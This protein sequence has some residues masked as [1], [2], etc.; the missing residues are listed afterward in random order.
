MLGRYLCPA[1]GSPAFTW[2]LPGAPVAQAH[3]GLMRVV[4]TRIG[5]DGTMKRR[6]VDT[7]CRTDGPRWE[8]LATRALG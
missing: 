6:M 7:G 5:Q 3:N 2:A 4:V 1:A 8:G